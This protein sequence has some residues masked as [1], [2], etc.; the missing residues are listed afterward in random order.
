MSKIDTESR[1]VI[2]GAGEKWGVILIT[3]EFVLGVIKLDLKNSDLG[4]LY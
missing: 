3:A 1:L 2:P 4:V